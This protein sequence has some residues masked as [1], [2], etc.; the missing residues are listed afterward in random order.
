[1]KKSSRHRLRFA[2]FYVAILFTVL[3]TRSTTAS[4][5]NRRSRSTASPDTGGA[6]GTSED[7]FASRA[8][9]G[10]VNASGY[11]ALNPR[12]SDIIQNQNSRRLK[13]SQ[14][15]GYVDFSLLGQGQGAELLTINCSASCTPREA[16]KQIRIETTKMDILRKLRITTLP[17]MTNHRIPN[18][19]FVQNLIERSNQQ[20]DSPY[21]TTDSWSDTN[22]K[23]LES[24]HST[25]VRTIIFPQKRK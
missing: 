18:I 10:R 13:D 22:D 5:P 17:N 3:T 8:I 2:V 6:G 11:A 12:A 19:P 24:D 14:G 9:I 4:R 15:G 7:E 23:E 21:A 20:N 25:T 1:M 16:L